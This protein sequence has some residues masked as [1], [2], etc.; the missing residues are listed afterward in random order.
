MPLAM[1]TIFIRM[2][3]S[4]GLLGVSGFFSWVVRLGH[5]SKQPLKGWRKVLMVNEY[6]FVVNTL[7]IC[8]GYY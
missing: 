6:W 5:D 7:L 4:F 2:I 1:S 3:I 8:G